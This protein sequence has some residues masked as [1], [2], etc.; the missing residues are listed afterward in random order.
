MSKYLHKKNSIN[1]QNII[2][3]IFL[4]IGI[5]IKIIL[6]LYENRF[7][8]DYKLKTECNKKII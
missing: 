5:V 7:P 2:D 6:N 1:Y 8:Y 4:Y 3:T